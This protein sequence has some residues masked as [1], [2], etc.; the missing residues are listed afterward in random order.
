MSSYSSVYLSTTT[1][2]VASRLCPRQSKPADRRRSHIIIITYRLRHHA[3]RL[4][5]NYV[6][7][8]SPRFYMI[9]IHAHSHAHNITHT[10]LFIYR[11]RMCVCVHLTVVSSGFISVWTMVLL[12]RPSPLLRVPQDTPLKRHTYPPPPAAIRF[13]WLNT[14]TQALARVTWNENVFDKRILWRV[15]VVSPYIRNSVAPWLLLRQGTHHRRQSYE[16][17]KY[18]IIFFPECRR[19]CSASV[20][21]IINNNKKLKLPSETK[22]YRWWISMDD[23]SRSL[24]FH[25]PDVVHHT[26]SSHDRN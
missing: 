14:H 8:R 21:R 11:V 19:C 3:N 24:E 18:I 9:C 2:T 17:G 6:C 25:R 7:L 13:R 16:L 1:Y 26:P 12:C 23:T 10:R 5:L 20:S 4:G 15:N 22:N